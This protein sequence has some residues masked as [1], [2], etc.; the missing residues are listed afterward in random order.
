MPKLLYQ[1]HA[2]YRLTAEDGRVMYVDPCSGDG[3]DAAA[4]IGAGAGDRII[5]CAS[6]TTVLQKYR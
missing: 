5:G 1:G 6:D 2:S 4:D 3:Y